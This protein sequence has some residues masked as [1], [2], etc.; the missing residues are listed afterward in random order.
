VKSLRWC[1]FQ[2]KPPS[3]GSASGPN[4]SNLYRLKQRV[5]VG[6]INIIGEFNILYVQNAAGAG[7]AVIFPVNTVLVVKE[8]PWLE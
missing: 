8:T 6:R 7:V 2:K 5:S 1:D 3:W 4:P